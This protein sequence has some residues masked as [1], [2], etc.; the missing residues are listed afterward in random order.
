MEKEIVATFHVAQWLC[1]HREIKEK[2][3]V[4][5]PREVRICSCIQ[6]PN[7]CIYTPEPCIHT[8][9]PCIHTPKPCFHTLGPCIHTPEP[10]I[11]TPEP[12]IHTWASVI[13]TCSQ[14]FRRKRR[15]ELCCPTQPFASSKQHQQRQSH[16]YYIITHSLTSIVLNSHYTTI[17]ME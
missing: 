14:S 10:C 15:V 3:H 13:H 16:S 17:C 2:V 9:E 5:Q 4:S 1:E 8:P 11:H 6:T 12:C 7:P